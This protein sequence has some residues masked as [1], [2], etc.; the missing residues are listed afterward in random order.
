MMN[1]KIIQDKAELERFVAWLP[2]C[3]PNEQYYVS[4]MSRKKYLPNSF[5]TAD[6]SQLKRFTATKDR[7]V[8]KLRQL[9][10][11]LGTYTFKDNPIPQEALAVYITPNPRDLTKAG[12]NMLKAIAEKVIR[13]EIYNP[14]SLALN[15]IQVSCSNKY[16]FDIDVDFL[17]ILPKESATRFTSDLS[18][19]LPC[20]IIKTHGGIH[21]LIH[22]RNIPED[23]KGRWYNYFT[24]FGEYWGPENF[25][26]VTMNGDNLIPIPGTCQGGFIPKML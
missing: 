2:D 1:Y 6:K 10:I 18:T 19:Y 4:L 25:F 22:L 8:A 20:T 12:L 7:I 24:Q 16:F 21:I 23:K 17:Q 5:L 14:K 15:M 26:T 13:K 11:E 9:E 3:Q